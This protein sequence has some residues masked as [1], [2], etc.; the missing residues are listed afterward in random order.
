M[1]LKRKNFG[2]AK[3]SPKYIEVND[4]MNFLTK[5]LKMIQTRHLPFLRKKFLFSYKNECELNF[6][7]EAASTTES[8]LIES[9]L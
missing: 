5:T 3:G 2:V 8:S 9:P 7:A 4:E 1:V 6:A